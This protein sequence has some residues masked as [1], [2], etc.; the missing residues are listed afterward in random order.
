MYTHL[1]IN[2]PIFRS[3]DAARSHLKPQGIAFRASPSAAFE[4]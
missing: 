1:A 3:I 2:E 4:N